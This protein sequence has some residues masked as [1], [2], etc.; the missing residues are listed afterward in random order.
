M[1][2]PEQEQYRKSLGQKPRS[3]KAQDA[4][5]RKKE[6]EEIVAKNKQF[7]DEWEKYKKTPE[8]KRLKEVIEKSSKHPYSE[9]IMHRI[10]Y[11]G[12][13]RE[14]YIKA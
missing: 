7:R 3:K 14:P 2:T 5:Q 13:W 4:V 6:L 11:A 1:L 10:F 9:N 12:Y 8:Y